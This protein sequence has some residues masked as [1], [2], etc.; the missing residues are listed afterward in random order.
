MTREE[1]VRLRRPSR[2]QATANRAAAEAGI[3][4]GRSYSDIAADLGITR[5]RVRQYA[6][7][8]GIEAVTARRVVRERKAERAQAEADELAARRAFEMD[9]EAQLVALVRGGMS[10]ARAARKMGYTRGQVNTM[11]KRLS[12]GSITEYGR[13]RN[14]STPERRSA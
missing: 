6:R 14:K 12:L 1:R 9:R 2:C 13:W 11:A 10:I 5:Q 3:R 8:L 4:A 7:D